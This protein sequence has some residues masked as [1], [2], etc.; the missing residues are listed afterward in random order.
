MLTNGTWP[1]WLAIGFAILLAF[2]QL[3]SESEKAAN[4]LGKFGRWIYSRARARRRMDTVE[5][6]EAVRKAVDKERQ[7]WE[8]DEAR[9]LKVMEERVAFI[10]ELTQEQ[11]R[12]L[13]E[14]TFE[15][16]CHRAYGDYEAAWH[17]RLRVLAMRADMNGGQIPI[18]TLPPHI[19]YSEFEDRC[20]AEK[21]MIWRDWGLL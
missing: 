10:T 16:R 12:Q 7:R 3:L 11:Q 13:R 9:E 5:F 6:T 20:R 21:T 8:D 2:N 1:A 19:M 18:E 17:N 14:I 4:V 15:L